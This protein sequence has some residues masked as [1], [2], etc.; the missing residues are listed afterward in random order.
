[1]NPRWLQE[2]DGSWTWEDRPAS[3]A[4]RLTREESGVYHWVA[5]FSPP[6]LPGGRT[7]GDA[8]GGLPDA[9]QAAVTA[10]KRWCSARTPTLQQPWGRRF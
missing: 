5:V 8:P 7:E 2:W 3:L 1:M 4:L 10:A 6:F 9:Q